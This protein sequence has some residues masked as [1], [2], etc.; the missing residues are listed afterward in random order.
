MWK[1]ILILEQD[2]LGVMLA[3]YH[4]ERVYGSREIIRGGQ[5][6]IGGGIRFADVI[7]M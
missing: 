4:L 6:W 7:Q 1:N 5:Y 2:L 3:F